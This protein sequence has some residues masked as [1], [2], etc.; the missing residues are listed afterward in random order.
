SLPDALPISPVPD[1]RLEDEATFLRAAAGQRRPQELLRLSGPTFAQERSCFYVGDLHMA[2]HRLRADYIVHYRDAEF[3]HF[4]HYA[5]RPHVAG[6]QPRL[7]AGNAAAASGKVRT[8]P[9][10][11]DPVRTVPEK[12]AYL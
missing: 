6:A 3:R 12:H 4:P 9:A 7:Y 1:E 10:A 2:S 5:R 8:G 11:A